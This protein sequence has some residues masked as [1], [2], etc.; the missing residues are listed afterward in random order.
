MVPGAPLMAKVARMEKKTNQPIG[1]AEVARMLT[2]AGAAFAT[3][4]NVKCRAT[5]GMPHWKN[6][7]RALG[8]AL[9]AVM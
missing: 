4:G 9:D 6:T 5:A 1:R 3:P 7:R 8:Y 2:G